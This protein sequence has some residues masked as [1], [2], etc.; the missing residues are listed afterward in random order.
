M[1]NVSHSCIPALEANG[2][3]TQAPTD[4]VR[5]KQGDPMRD[6]RDA[7]LM[8]RSLCEAMKPK[9]L[10]LTHS[11]SLELIAAIFGVDN[12]NMLSAQIKAKEEASSERPH[13]TFRKKSSGEVE[14]LVAGPGVYI[15]DQCIALC[16]NTLEERSIAKLLRKTDP[17]S[18]P[19]DHFRD[20]STEQILAYQRDAQRRLSKTRTALRT[21]EIL[22]GEAADEQVAPGPVH[23]IFRTKSKR[24]LVATK[25]Q[26]KKNLDRIE[27]TLRA[28]DD[29]LR[30][31]SQP[32]P[33]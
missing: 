10:V 24:D 3:A 12:W 14:A 2:S 15:C 16:S 28:V 1:V 17:A 30:V 4:F 6:F 7:K 20:R 27:S 31:R 18:A 13:C 25:K 19:A 33:S 21:V 22:I 23:E 26:L 32:A 8:A 11:E 29:V 9:S 5:W